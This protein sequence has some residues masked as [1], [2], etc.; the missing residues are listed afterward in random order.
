MCTLTNA[1]IS[2]CIYI[3]CT[4]T[5]KLSRERS[6]FFSV[7]DGSPVSLEFPRNHIGFEMFEYRELGIRSGNTMEPIPTGGVI[8][9]VMEADIGD[10]WWNV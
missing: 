3:K 10:T 2:I 4:G 9:D 6:V 5:G 7:I 1:R 8:T